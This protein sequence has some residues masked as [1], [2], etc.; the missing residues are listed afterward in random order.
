MSPV[1]KPRNT[2]A[3][4]TANTR[5]FSAS[6]SIGPSLIPDSVAPSFR[7]LSVGICLSVC[8]QTTGASRSSLA[9]ESGGVLV[10][11]TLAP[12]HHSTPGRSTAAP[13]S[14]RCTRQLRRQLVA[15]TISTCDLSVREQQECPD[16]GLPA[17]VRLDGVHVDAV[18][19]VVVND[20][21]SHRRIEA[22]SFDVLP[23]ILRCIAK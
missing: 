10:A 7:R 19:A 23:T 13:R 16:L 21:A 12:V 17:A 4:R 2:E 22:L 20:H 5:A 8:T 9:R 14:T 18:V 15:L 3:D 11:G 1:R 6:M